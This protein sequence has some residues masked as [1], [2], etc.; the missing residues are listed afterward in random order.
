MQELKYIRRRNMSTLKTNYIK[1]SSS[2][3]NNITLNADG[4][5]TINGY[6]A[7]DVDKLQQNQVVLGFKLAATSSLTKYSLSDQIIDDF[8]DL[9]GVDTANSTNEVFETGQIYGTDGNASTWCTG[10]TV[11]EYSLGGTDYRVHSFLSGTNTFTVPVSGTVDILAVAGGGAG[12]AGKNGSGGG[13]GGMIA[14]AGVTVTPGSYSFVV[15]AGG[16][17]APAVGSQ[18]SSAEYGGDGENTTTGGITATAVGG[19]AGVSDAKDHDYAGR[20]GGSGG[21]GG[22]NSGTAGTGTA[23]Q[24]NAAGSGPANEGGGGTNKGQGGGGAGEVGNTDGR[25][26]GGDGLENAYRTGSNVFYAG[27]GGAGMDAGNSDTSSASGGGGLGKGSNA[28]GGDGTANTG[29]GGGGGGEGFDRTGGAGGSGI[30]VVRY[31]KATQ[32]LN[33][34]GGDLTLQST[35]TTASSQPDKADL[36]ILIENASGTAT[37][38]THVKGYVSR[39]GSQFSSAVNLVDEG[40]VLG[41][42]Q[43]LFVAHDI[44]I[45]GLNAGTSMK[46]KVTT[47]SQSNGGRIT[48]IRGVSLGWK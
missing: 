13:A 23:G 28:D 3:V 2:S 1:H 12:G 43:R 31:N 47:H 35:A 29:G 22:E 36:Y 32:F 10:G 41:T 42:N 20:N 21:G 39:D 46:Y 17:T 33:R 18:T 24:G 34:A 26:E 6:N 48:K 25:R 40:P 19:G 5:V 45:S 16:A 4:T 8:Q 14:T 44:D 37:Q 38:N 27:G 15:G 9:S 30:V 7:D 11:T